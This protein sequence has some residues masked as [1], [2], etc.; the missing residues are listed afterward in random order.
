MSSALPQPHTGALSGVLGLGTDG[1]L[2]G[3]AITLMVASIDVS[4]V[5]DDGGVKIT[6]TGTFPIGSILTVAVFDPISGLTRTCYSGIIGQGANV[7]SEDGST[8]SFVVPPMPV[9]GINPAY[10]LVFNPPSPFLPATLAAVITY[11]HRT[12]TS[13][14]YSLRNATGRPRFTGAFA[15]EDED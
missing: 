4:E 13:V 6:A 15:L 5:P 2:S 11:Y 1:V 9:N 12:Y 10:D 3:A 14:L 8:V 7:Q